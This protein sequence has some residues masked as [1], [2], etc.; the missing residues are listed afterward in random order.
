MKNKSLRKNTLSE[1]GEV[2]MQRFR[3]TAAE[4]VLSSRQARL[5]KR[6]ICLL[7][8]K[9]GDSQIHIWNFAFFQL[10]MLLT[11][12]TVIALAPLYDPGRTELINFIDLGHGLVKVT[13]HEEDPSEHENM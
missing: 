13:F 3:N 1:I 5:F 7:T 11:C 2:G 4:I 12:P 6:L 8:Q 10:R 9:T